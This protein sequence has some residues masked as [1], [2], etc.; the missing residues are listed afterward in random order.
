MANYPGSLPSSSPADHTAVNNEII[1][2]AKAPLAKPPY[3]TG[4]VYSNVTVGPGQ[5]YAEAS[6]ALIWHPFPPGTVLA[7]ITENVTTAGTAGAVRRLGAYAHDAST[8]RP[9]SL[10]WD[11]GTYDATTTGFKTIVISGGLTL[12][13]AYGVWLGGA[14]QGAA[15][16]RPV[17]TGVNAHQT[18]VSQ[19]TAGSVA[20][21]VGYEQTSVTGALPGTFTATPNLVGAGSYQLVKIG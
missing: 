2:I 19:A 10:L 14:T 1:A 8:G 5:T 13:S 6:L 16:T 3:V 17:I 18:A 9:G 15:G 20:I 12:T 11:G 21:L 7:E 4:R